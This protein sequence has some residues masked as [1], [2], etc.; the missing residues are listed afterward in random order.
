MLVVRYCVW[1]WAIGLARGILLSPYENRPRLFIHDGNFFI[2][3]GK[4][5][6]ITFIANGEGT[7]LFGGLDIRTLP[8]VINQVPSQSISDFRPMRRQ[9]RQ[10]SRKLNDLRIIV[11]RDECNRNPCKN[12]GTCIDGINKYYCLCPDQFTGENCREDI[13]ECVLYHDTELGCQN[14]GTCIN[15]HGGFRCQ[16]PSNWHGRRCTE[17]KDECTTAGSNALCGLHGACVTVKDPGPGEASYRCV[18]DVGWQQ[19][20]SISNPYCEDID[21]CKNNPC[22]HGSACYN[23]PGKF[24]CGSCPEGYTG[25]GV[26][27]W[28]VNECLINNGGCSM[29]PQVPCINTYGSFHCGSCPAGFAG[30]GVVCTK[31]FGCQQKP[32]HA[33]ATCSES[34]DFVDGFHCQCPPDYAG[35]GL[36]PNGCYPVE[37]DPCSS[38]PCLNGGSCQALSSRSFTCHCAWGYSGQDCSQASP[39]LSAP[40]QNNGTCVSKGNNQ[41]KC[42]CKFGNYGINCELREEGCSGH[43][44]S[45]S[46]TLKYPTVG[47][48][49]PGLETC[50]WTITVSEGMVVNVTF[51]QFDIERSQSST[52]DYCRFDNLTIFDGGDMTSPEIGIYCGMIGQSTA[53]DDYILSSGNRLHLLFRTDGSVHRMGFSLNWTAT[54][55]VCGG[56]LYDTRGAITSPNY[57]LQYGTNLHCSGVQCCAQNMQIRDGERSDDRLMSQYCTSVAPT[58]SELRSSLPYVFVYFRSSSN[59]DRRSDSDGRFMIQFNVEETWVGYG[60][61]GLRA[62][63][64]R[65]HPFRIA[66]RRI[67]RRCSGDYVEIRDGGD[68]NA[69]LISNLCGDTLPETITSTSSKL[70]VLFHSE[71]RYAGRGFSAQYEIKCGAI[72]N[73]ENGTFQ[74]PNFP[75]PHRSA[76][77]CEYVIKAPPHYAI[78]LWFTAVE[79]G[80]KLF[81][82]CEENYITL[83]APAASSWFNRH[84]CVISTQK[85]FITSGGTMKIY[86]HTNG[87]ELN[88]GFQARFSTYDIGCGGVLTNMRGTFQSPGH[89][90][91]YFH[92]VECR[93]DIILPMRFIAKVVFT[94]FVL[95]EHQD[96]RFDHVEFYESYVSPNETSGF[97]GR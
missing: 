67:R 9:L 7:V 40:C 87:S 83:E 11:E 18:C 5:K 78:E 58:V 12:G 21:E 52:L 73:S 8:S 85:P 42:I 31:E 54:V 93:W 1:L 16:C 22:F 23:L 15:I 27:C 76:V 92:N 6:N 88:H 10:L 61:F 69:A 60:Y 17:S 80:N 53:P 43:Y 86:F 56:R 65:L 46:G 44:Q 79:L 50:K 95:E 64:R 29:Q 13:D 4:D 97:L 89:P 34:A 55:P 57:P 49:Y 51:V 59:I 38:H 72:L 32:C 41:Y 68:E 48:T 2:H 35:T 37:R 94:T 74:S 77:V 19:S 84:F 82:S 45:D 71:D 36:G 47:L 66:Y 90:N 62:Q 30:N 63:D 20:D 24:R 25:N 81:Y 75:S 70:W 3:A 28:D 96:C 91:D 33:L 26:Q 14:G 39:C